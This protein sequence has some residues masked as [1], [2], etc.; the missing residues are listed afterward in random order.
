MFN[1]SICALSAVSKP[2]FFVPTDS[3]IKTGLPMEQGNQGIW[4]LIREFY[5]KLLISYKHY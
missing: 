3:H 1:V 4:N 2:W 5:I